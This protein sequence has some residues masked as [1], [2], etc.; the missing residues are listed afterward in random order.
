MW[1]LTRGVK[2]RFFTTEKFL[3]PQNTY[4]KWKGEGVWHRWQKRVWY[5]VGV[6]PLPFSFFICILGTEKFSVVKN[7]FFTPQLNVTCFNFARH[8]VI[9]VGCDMSQVRQKTKPFFLF[10]RRNLLSLPYRSFLTNI[11]TCLLPQKNGLFYTFI[12]FIM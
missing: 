12:I 8:Y 4:K 10:I 3:S 7:L 9:L 5:V 11:A 6:T 1:H 2:N